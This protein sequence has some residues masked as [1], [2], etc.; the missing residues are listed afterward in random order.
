MLARYRKTTLS[1]DL[2][3]R[4]IHIPIFLILYGNVHR[5]RVLRILYK[6]SGL[7]STF[8]MTKQHDKNVS[9]VNNNKN[10]YPNLKQ[11]FINAA[12]KN[13]FVF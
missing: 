1:Y 4:L 13:L 7:E 8:S 2:K 11:H 6:M 9:N 5:K 12:R 3:M 10:I